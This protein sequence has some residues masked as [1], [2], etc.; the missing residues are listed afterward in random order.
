M[1]LNK[2]ILLIIVLYVI[3]VWLY[4]WWPNT[5]ASRYSILVLPFVSPLFALVLLLIGQAISY[6]VFRD[7]KQLHRVI[8]GLILIY[9]L[10]LAYMAIFYLVILLAAMTGTLKVGLL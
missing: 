5:G 1:R 2:R 7:Y 4:F 8:L 9:P 6:Y 10:Y 3:Y